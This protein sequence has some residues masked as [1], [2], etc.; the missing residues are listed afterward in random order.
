MSAVREIADGYLEQLAPHEPAAAQS[1]GLGDESALPDYSPGWYSDRHELDRSTS[2][3]LG[4]A[5]GNADAVLKEA[6]AERLASYQSLFDTGF[7]TRLL[8]PLATPVHFLREEFEAVT[9]TPDEAGDA[10]LERLRRAPAALADYTET[11]RWSRAE[12]DCGRFSGTGVAGATQV[13]TV[14][15]QVSTWIDLDF[16]R[17]IPI[18][19]RVTADKRAEF[20]KA[21]DEMT[22]ASLEFVRFLR[23]DLLPTAPTRDA[24]GDEVYGATARSFLG[25]PLDLDE[26]Y[27]FGWSELHRLVDEARVLATSLGGSA[28]PEDALR[29]VAAILD[30]QPGQTLDGVTGIQRWLTGRVED[31]IRALD[32]DAF[33]LPAN[34]RDVD[35]IVSKAA[36]GV[37]YYTP[38]PPDAS[39]KARI[40][41]TVPNEEAA[42]TTWREV[43]SLHHEGVPGHHLEHSINRANLDLHPWQRNLCHVHGYA[44]GWAHYSEGLADELGLFRDEPERLGML[45]GQI[46]RSVRIVADIGLHTGRRIPRTSLTAETEWSP[47][48]ARTFLRELSLTDAR[49]ARFEVDRYLGWPGQA[50][51]FKVGA[52][53]WQDARVQAAARP[54]F[55]LK[56]FH[57]D[58]LALGPMGLGPL[59]ASLLL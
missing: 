41:W 18:D 19:D 58:A 46:W 33:D 13:R 43:S 50:L 51:A 1:I 30:A 35:C 27:D 24:V 52:K 10:I 47:E 44:E 22:A 17:S 25:A 49:T 53:L 8:A 9:V 12:G 40:V 48:V 34:I 28:R 23:D 37:V 3:A 42:P 36:A 26:I 59:R 56:G 16:Y 21:A 5:E 11:L 57:R 14:A 20:D 39:A 7:T 2:A 29:S 6:F 55:T 4:L 31:T 54:G 45:L 15:D 38:A 32:G